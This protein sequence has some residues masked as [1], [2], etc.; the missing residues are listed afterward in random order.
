MNLLGGNNSLL[1]NDVGIERCL[2]NIKKTL[3]IM[4]PCRDDGE[5][6]LGPLIKLHSFDFLQFHLGVKILLKIIFT[7]D[8][9]IVETVA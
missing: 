7:G 6:P 2:T 8:P 1:Q 5:C 3:D 4:I 9:C